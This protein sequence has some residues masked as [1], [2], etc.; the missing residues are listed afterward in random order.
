MVTKNFLVNKLNYTN[1]Q[2]RTIIINLKHIQYNN[3]I[4]LKAKP[5]PCSGDQ[6]QCAWSGHHDIGHLLKSYTFSNFLIPEGKKL[7]K[8]I[9]EVLEI[10]ATGLSL[11]LPETGREITARKVKRHAASGITI[12]MT[13]NSVRFSGR[14]L[15]FSP[16]SFSA[17]LALLP[18]QTFEWVY[19][20]SPVNLQF[21]S[22]AEILYSGECRIIRHDGGHTIRKFA[23]E[24]V[25]G[26]HSEEIQA[27]AVPEQPPATAATRPTSCSF[28]RSP[29]RRLTLMF[30]I[31]REPGFPLKKNLKIQCFFP[32]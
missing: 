7:Y 5:L 8:V 21:F 3:S 15:D 30:R 17:E 20:D 14:L 29:A 24:P 27:E 32:E 23:F 1:F 26:A 25:D 6:L 11:L 16:V 2:D 10:T 31:Y 9:P 13:Q 28:T 19:L 22:G 18:R 4:S 12:Q